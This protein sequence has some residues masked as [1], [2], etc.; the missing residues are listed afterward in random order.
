MMV[1]E[2]LTP[3]STIA[4][5][6]GITALYNKQLTH[7]NHGKGFASMFFILASSVLP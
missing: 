4:Y 1:S 7:L 5:I 2:M 6:N 3:L